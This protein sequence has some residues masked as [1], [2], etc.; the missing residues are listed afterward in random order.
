MTEDTKELPPEDPAS[1]K[2]SLDDDENKEIAELPA[3]EIIA[4]LLENVDEGT[5]TRVLEMSQKRFSGP[6]PPPE[7]LAE[8][9]E[10]NEGFANRIIS[11][12][13]RQQAHRHDIEKTSVTAAISSEKRG[14]DYAL[15]VCVLVILASTIVTALGHV[16]SGTII[17]GGSLT[18]LAYI[19]ISGKK[20]EEKE[21]DKPGNPNDD[22]N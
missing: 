6:L 10:I 22:K 19:F 3:E 2:S 9:D 4:E 8:Y 14:Q 11:L 18:G 13:E 20:Y 5:I 1:N 21:K 7:M 15:I 17:M 12:T 16:I